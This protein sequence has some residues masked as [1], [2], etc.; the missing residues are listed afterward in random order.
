M[1]MKTRFSHFAL[2]ACL[3]VTFAWPCLGQ[4]TIYRDRSAFDTAISSITGVRT[5][6]N[7]GPPLPPGGVGQLEW[8]EY[9]SPLTVSGLTFR[10]GGPLVI[11]LDS[12]I[13]E[14]NWVLNNYDSLSPLTVDMNGPALAFGADFSSWPQPGLQQLSGDRH[15]R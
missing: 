14:P 1:N 5:D 8:M 11:R 10:S 6:L 4:G 9:F 12:I 2:T 3:T 7:F 13:P 15:F